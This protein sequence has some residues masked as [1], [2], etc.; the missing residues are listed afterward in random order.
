MV[1]QA[2]KYTPSPTPPPS[3]VPTISPIPPTLSII[4]QLHLP[5]QLTY[6]LI[7]SA[8][9][10][11]NAIFTMAVRG[12]PAIALVA[13][14]AVSVASHPSAPFPITPYPTAGLEMREAI[15]GMLREIGTARPTAVN[16]MDAVRKLEKVVDGAVS[17]GADA[18]EVRDAYVVAAEKM[19]A[20]DVSD[21]QNIGENGA[22][23]LIEYVGR[24]TENGASSGREMETMAVLTHC[25]TG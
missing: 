24:G 6:E 23:W 17:K 7:T 21:N 19:L 14:L 5:H 25:N 1:L 12:A 20:D 10:V 3:S 13:V 18:R 4:N 11:H 9:E 16:L 8:A 15:V 22:K 2:I